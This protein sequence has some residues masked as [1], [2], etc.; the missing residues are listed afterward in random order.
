MI[1]LIVILPQ[2][3]GQRFQIGAAVINGQDDRLRSL[4]CGRTG[5]RS[6]NRWAWETT[7][8]AIVGFARDSHRRRC[9]MP[10]TRSATSASVAKRMTGMSAV[11]SRLLSSRGADSMPSASG[12]RTSRITQSN[13]SFRRC[14]R[15]AEADAHSVVAQPAAPERLVQVHADRQAVINDQHSSHSGLRLDSVLLR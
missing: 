4:G 13:D 12:S 3:S 15:A 2:L 10:L 14:S 6:A 9:R 8:C 1:T 11:A 5:R 7:L